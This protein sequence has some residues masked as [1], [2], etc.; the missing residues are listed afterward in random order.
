[1][2]KNKKDPELEEVDYEEV[3]GS[4]SNQ[5]PA[6]EQ[7]F[8]TRYRNLL[9]AGVGI[10]ALVVVAFFFYRDM[11]RQ[12]HLDASREMFQAIYYFEQDSLDLALNGSGQFL[13]LLDI[14]DDYSGTDAA[15][16]ARYYVGVIHLKKGELE[17][18]VDYLKDF[19]TGDNMLSMAAYMALGFAYE[20]LG[21]P[22]QAA[23]YFERAANTPGENESTTPTMLLHAAQNYE[24]AGDA[25]KALE[26]YREI[27]QSYPLT[28]E[29]LNVDKYI[30]RAEAK[31]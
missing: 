26:L 25:G 6:E 21:D 7:D 20:D 30:G 8:I 19:S 2:A 23:S 27:K 3:A 5:Q 31:Q 9:L 11:Q 13:G 15:N 18:G 4:E 28:T 24:A 1:M 12:K 16:Q 14:I 10:V 22:A 29:G 17:T